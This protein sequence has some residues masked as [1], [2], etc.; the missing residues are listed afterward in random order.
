MAWTGSWPGTTRA[1]RVEAAAFQGKPVFFSLIGDWT[2]P[3]RMQSTDKKSI[4]EQATRIISV[5]VLCT[6]L[7]FSV[8]L[9]RRNYRQ[10]RGDRAGALRLAGV[11]FM[12]EMSLWLCRGHFA[13]IGDTLGLF[14]IGSA[15]RC[16]FLALPGCCTWR[17][18]R[19]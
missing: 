1:L 2:K 3:E 9:A 10:G 5:V 12:L 14:V 6:L 18:N 4:G 7:G 8:L 16:L 19:G 13:T 15:P 17:W 11:M